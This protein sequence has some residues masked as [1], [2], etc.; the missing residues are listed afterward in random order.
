MADSV[1]WVERLHEVVDELAAPVARANAA[2]LTCRSGCS[3]CC[4]D[5]LTVFAIEAAVIE[6]HYP[7]LL[8]TGAPNE[9]GGCAFLDAEGGC[10]VYPHRPYVC[11]TQGLPL[12]WI[13][14]DEEQDGIVEGRDICPLNADGPPLEELSAENCWTIGPIEE[15]LA[16]QQRDGLRVALRS[17]FVGGRRRLPIA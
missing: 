12:R 3:S 15:R 9:A 8:A 10:R 13:E 11:R 16:A 14:E 6:R 5:G 4:T 7:D 2:R 1:D 17:L